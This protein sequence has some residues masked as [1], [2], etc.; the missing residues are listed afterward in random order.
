MVSYPP[1]PFRIKMV[2]PIQ[3]VDRQQRTESLRRA[4]YNLFGLRSDEI[5]ID[6]LTDSGTGAMSQAQ[7]A[8]LM[9]GDE[10]YAGARS[11][12]HLAE[13]IHDIFGFRFFTPTHQGRA[14]ENILCALMVKEGQYVP[15]NMHFDTTDA[16][17]RARGGHPTNLVIA[18]AYEPSNRHPFK[19]N[20][21]VQKLENFIAEVGVDR[22]PL[23]M[24]TITNNAGGGQPVSLENIRTVA[25]IY[26]AHGIPFFIDACRYAENAYFIKE[27]EPGYVDKSPLEIARQIFALADGATMSAKKDAI[28]NIGGFLAMNDEDLYRR[29]CNELILREGFPTYGGLAGRDLDAI[30]VGLREGLD[31][32]YLAYRLGQ[33]AYLAERL[34]ELGIPIIEPPGGHAVYLDAGR[35][36]PHIP[37]KEFPGQALAVEL[38]LEGGIRA[39]EIGSVMFAHPDPE[40]NELTYP[41]LELVRLAI[42]RRVYTQSH[43]DYVAETLAV[44]A[45]HKEDVRGYRFTYAPPLLRHFTARFE[46]LSNQR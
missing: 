34:L 29:A 7:W 33:T 2:E 45:K 22:I 14:A 20:M 15:S 42:P 41:K 17:I 31:E 3:Q 44:I 35:L 27:R 36:L 30:A 23:G 1:E 43:L 10:S 32:N 18:A 19:G 4:G 9:L 13:A 8:A 6:L 11:F 39:V 21:D 28:V 12:F 26:H 5:F 24:I 40:T 38:Y 37:Q 46:P 25:Q 16:N